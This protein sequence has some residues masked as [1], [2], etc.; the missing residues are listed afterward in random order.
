LAALTNEL[1]HKKLAL[2]NLLLACN[3]LSGLPGGLLMRLSI[4]FLALAFVALGILTACNSA[5]K[6]ART[7]SVATA[8]TTAP[9]PADGVRRVTVAELK[10]LV[11]KNEAFIIDVRNE[12]SYNAAHIRGSKLIPEAD[13]LKHVDEL[14]RNKLIVT[15]CS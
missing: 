11:A 14:P 12:A 15:Y 4:S 13:I 5:E 10:D 6:N 8:P 1:G 2:D 3:R 9:P 7:S